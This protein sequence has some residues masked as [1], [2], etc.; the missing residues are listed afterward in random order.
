MR[1]SPLDPEKLGKRPERGA[2]FAEAGRA[3]RFFVIIVELSVL[4]AR[5]PG[6]VGRTKVAG[7]QIRAYRY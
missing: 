5:E 7:G 1:A 4:G 3:R 6:D 2:Q